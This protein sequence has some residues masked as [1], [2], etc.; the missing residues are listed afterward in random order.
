V[1]Q[2]L[3]VGVCWCELA[4]EEQYE[5]VEGQTV[6]CVDVPPYNRGPVDGITEDWEQ[7]NNIDL[8]YVHCQ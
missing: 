5:C 1:E 2:C 8:T 3:Y 4:N 7:G 6:C